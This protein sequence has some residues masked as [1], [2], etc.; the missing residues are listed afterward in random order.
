[1]RSYLVQPKVR[2][3]ATKPLKGHKP[4]SATVTQNSINNNFEIQHNIKKRDFEIKKHNT[5]QHKS[6]GWSLQWEL[7]WGTFSPS[8]PKS[9]LVK[10]PLTRGSARAGPLQRVAVGLQFACRMVLPGECMRAHPLMQPACVDANA[11]KQ[12]VS[13]FESIRLHFDIMSGTG[14]LKRSRSL[15]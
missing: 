15:L 10:R 7:G 12:P 13:D 4:K 5:T 8:P 3:Q 11:P 6:G 9:G 1:M 14:R 2:K